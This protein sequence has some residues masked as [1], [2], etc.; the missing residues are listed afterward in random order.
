[1]CN[2]DQIA[3]HPEARDFDLVGRE[4]ASHTPIFFQPVVI[5]LVPLPE[6][7]YFTGIAAHDKGAAWNPDQFGVI[8]GILLDHHPRL[9]FLQSSPGQSHREIVTHF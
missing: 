2:R 7:A 5:P 1:L 9:V 4:F 8:F 3:V 6:I